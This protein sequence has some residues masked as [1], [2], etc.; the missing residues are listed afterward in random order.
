MKLSLRCDCG[1][2]RGEV[3]GGAPLNYGICYCK[4][5]QAFAY[6]LGKAE[7]MLDTQGG[8]RILQTA[9]WCVRFTAGQHQLRC[10]RLTSKGLVRWYAGCCDTAIGNTPASPALGF[11]G[12]IGSCL[13]EVPAEALG[14]PRMRV[15]TR[16]AWGTPKPKQVISI[17]AL[18][19]FLRIVIGARFARAGSSPFHV[20]GGATSVEPRILSAQE[21]E[22]VTRCC[23]R[24]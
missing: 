5:C 3:A 17:G 23:V 7:S 12:L 9:A 2:L 19:A 15:W 20:A 4:D 10:L 24:Q 18:W 1:E 14:P 6:A 13:S 22:N 21:L 16:S 11:V 8:T